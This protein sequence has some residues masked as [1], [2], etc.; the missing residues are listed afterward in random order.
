MKQSRGYSVLLLC[1]ITSAVYTYGRIYDQPHFVFAANTY[2][3]EQHGFSYGSAQHSQN[4]H[5]HLQPRYYTLDQHTI[6][7]L[8]SN[9]NHELVL[10]HGQE[11]LVLSLHHCY[12]NQQLLARIKAL[13]DRD[14]QQAV[15]NA[16]H[17]VFDTV[18]GACAISANVIERVSQSYMDLLREVHD[19]V[20]VCIDDPE[21]G[22]QLL[23]TCSEYI[24][25]DIA[26]GVATIQTT[27][28][29][30]I[31]TA[32]QWCT[33]SNLRT[34]AAFTTEHGVKLA[35]HHCLAKTYTTIAGHALTYAAKAVHTA[36]SQ[37]LAEGRECFELARV[38]GT[39]M[40]S[41]AETSR[42]AILS[43]KY[44]NVTSK[45]F[46][47]HA[48]EYAELAAWA[49]QLSHMPAATAQA[50]GLKT[51]IASERFLEHIFSLELKTYFKKSGSI[52]QKIN[53]F[54]AFIA[55][56]LEEHGIQLLNKKVCEKTG[57]MMA[58]V[59][60][61][62]Y[63]EEGKTFFPSSWTRKTVLE[64]IYE[65]FHGLLEEPIFDQGRWI[66]RGKTTDN[67][68]IRTVLS[69]LGELITSY[70]EFIKLEIL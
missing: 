55:G 44:I 22:Y 27:A 2:E 39:K 28:D 13:S 58:D 61:E 59:L 6:T 47:T 30:L 9:N 11:Q 24:H 12:D 43:S 60:C 40:A 20:A 29:Y 67:I 17:Y 56:F 69:E 32:P 65:S 41:F 37:I 64:K 42:Q 63:L 45:F 16:G 33:P 51:I 35:V 50:T 21:L 36:G 3:H 34:V 14:P 38:M 53:G 62:G 52:R 57:I 15:C 8:L 5:S 26:A 19:V 66:I 31:A 4:H 10:S 49:S 54:H 25:D 1:I 7:Y 46:A 68:V 18:H 23:S 48:Y 70:P